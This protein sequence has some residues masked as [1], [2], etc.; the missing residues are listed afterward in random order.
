[1]CEVIPH[2]IRERYKLAV[3]RTAN[4]VI[5]QAICENRVAEPQKIPTELTDPV[6]ILKNDPEPA[7]K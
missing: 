5:D 6:V 4:E 2:P 1:L 3:P 7:G